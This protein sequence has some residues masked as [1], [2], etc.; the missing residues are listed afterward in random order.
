MNL[1]DRN[2]YISRT[3]EKGNDPL[4]DKLGGG[5]K[6]VPSVS[7]FTVQKCDEFRSDKIA[8][9]MFGDS[10]LYWVVLE[11][12]GLL[13]NYQLFVGTVLRVPNINYI[14]NLFVSSTSTT[15]TT[16]SVLIP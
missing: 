10:Q 2:T 12:N 16:T 1:N 14:N 9:K 3:L 4:T 8:A 6:N 13:S 11:Y 7:T 5:L 15:N